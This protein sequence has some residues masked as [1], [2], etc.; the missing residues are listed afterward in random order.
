MRFIQRKSNANE[1]N[2]TS[3]DVLIC[4]ADRK[5]RVLSLYLYNPDTVT[6]PT[7]VEIEKDSQTP[8]TF[9]EYSLPPGDSHSLFQDNVYLEPGDKITVTTT[10]I[11]HSIIS[12]KEIKAI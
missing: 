2:N 8:V 6:S 11:V 1:I 9:F 5:V 12:F 3:Q 10:G 7:T 4:P